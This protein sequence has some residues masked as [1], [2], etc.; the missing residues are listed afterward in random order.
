M[1]DNE[2]LILMWSLVATVVRLEP[3]RHVNASS[4]TVAGHTE[5]S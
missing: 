4:L 3:L 1:N 2:F 5:I